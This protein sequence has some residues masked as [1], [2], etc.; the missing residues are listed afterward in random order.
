VVAVGVNCTDPS[1]VPA[2]VQVAAAASG[3]PVVAYPNSGEVWDAAARRWTGSPGVGD[4]TSWLAA[5]ARLV[6][7]CCRVRPDDVA[8]IAAAVG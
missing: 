6:G 4:V 5:G 8:A 1:G 2:A 3:R 7:G